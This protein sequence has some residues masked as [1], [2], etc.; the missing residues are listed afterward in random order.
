MHHSPN[1][2]FVHRLL[3]C[4]IFFTSALLQTSLLKPLDDLLL[5]ASLHPFLKPGSEGSLSVFKGLQNNLLPIFQRFNIFFI[6]LNMVGREAST[7]G[8]FCPRVGNG[9]DDPFF[10]KLDFAHLS[11]RFPHPSFGDARQRLPD[12]RNSIEAM[13]VGSGSSGHGPLRLCRYR[14]GRW[15]RRGRYGGWRNSGRGKF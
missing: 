5:A 6:V 4:H 2:R 15:R 1:E 14:C 3:L 13:D 11:F 7:L 12:G 9:P 10:L 8:N